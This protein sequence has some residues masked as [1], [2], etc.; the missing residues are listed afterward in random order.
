MHT[1][2]PANNIVVV[3]V[4]VLVL[5]LVPDHGPGRGLGFWAW[6]WSWSGLLAGWLLFE[7][8][9]LGL[10]LRRVDRAAGSGA[11][12]ARPLCRCKPERHG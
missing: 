9:L 11:A 12:T 6:L 3:L 2:P 10:R 5:V 4:M 7:L 1:I 8:G